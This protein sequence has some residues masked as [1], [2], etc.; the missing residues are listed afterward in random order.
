MIEYVILSSNLRECSRDDQ[1]S[2]ASFESIDDH[3]RQIL[4]TR[5]GY[6][7][8]SLIPSYSHVEASLK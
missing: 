3:G 2:L 5:S 7:H 4:D 8:A 6:D 1:T